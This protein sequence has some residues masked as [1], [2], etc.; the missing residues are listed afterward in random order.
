MPFRNREL[1]QYSLTYIHR[2]LHRCRK[3]WPLWPREQATQ[4]PCAA[5]APR[6][7]SWASDRR[8]QQALQIAHVLKV[9]VHHISLQQDKW[10]ITSRAHG[11]V[12]S[13]IYLTACIAQDVH[14]IHMSPRFGCSRYAPISNAATA[15]GPV[16]TFFCFFSYS[17]LS[18][19]RY[20]TAVPALDCQCS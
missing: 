9:C 13:H 17:W 18:L 15:S 20:R 5:S 1:K 6:T 4:H 2:N 11:R 3:L 8:R 19:Q 16:R 14:A 10:C 7:V 12:R